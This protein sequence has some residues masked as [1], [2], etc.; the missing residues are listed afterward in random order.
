MNEQTPM[1]L[2][3]KNSQQPAPVLQG[4][5]AEGR[6]DGVL[7]ELCVRQSYR[8][9]SEEVL[10]VVYTFPLPSQGVL[11]GFASELNGKRMEGA[12]TARR[13][14]EAR[15]EAALAEGDAPVMLEALQ[16]G[17]HTANIGNLKPGEQIVLEVRFAQLLRFEQGRLR[18]A[19]PTT[20]APRFG[21]ASAAGLQPQQVPQVSMQA[22]HVLQLAITVA[23]SLA[24]A[25][26][27]CPT[28]AIRQSH[29]A[30]SVRI[31]LANQAWLDRDVVLI[32][33]PA[34]LRAGLALQAKDA[35]N[36][37]APLLH[38]AALAPW[39]TPARERINLRLLVDCSGSMGG[40]SIQSAR[41]ALASAVA[42]LR[43]QDSVSLSRFGSSVEHMARPA[44][45]QPAV[46]QQLQQRISTIQA[47]MGGTEMQAALSSTFAL[48]PPAAVKAPGIKAGTSTQVAD[49][50][51]ITDGEIWQTE[52]VIAAARASGQRIFA[53]G[54]GSSPAEH[55]LRALADATGGACEFA[56]PGE[57]LAAA[58]RRMM[59]RIRQQVWRDVR[60]EWGTEAA[61]QSAL[62]GG[63]FDGD[64]VFAWAGMAASNNAQ[65]V[66]LTAATPNGER[67]ELAR[68]AI[69]PS[70]AGISLSRMAAA[71]RMLG[72]DAST[73]LQLA[74]RYQLMSPQTNCVMVHQRAEA[75]KAAQ[76]AVLHQVTSMMAAGWGATGTVAPGTPAAAAVAPMAAAA[77]PMDALDMFSPSPVVSTSFDALAGPAAAAEAG[78]AAPQPMQRK[79]VE[80]TLPRYAAFALEKDDASQRSRKAPTGG[81]PKPAQAPQ[82]PAGIEL[83]QLAQTVV[84]LL[85]RSGSLPGLAVAMAFEAPLDEAMREV[86]QQLRALG[87]DQDAAWAVLAYWSYQRQTAT[88]P[89]PTPFAL[90]RLLPALDAQQVASATAWLDS[91]LGGSTAPAAS[92]DPSSSRLAR[93]RKALGRIGG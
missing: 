18:L 21:N 16:D 32:V 81:M 40:D 54:V 23:G 25:S 84:R 12:I 78:G 47:D 3:C 30:D 10:E 61:W 42:T 87:L 2:C 85:E 27:E 65:N 71:N 31:E 52:E 43:P 79:Q 93:L 86:L 26:I 48:Q 60:I 9:T 59:A 92:P 66:R 1:G 24:R 77:A 51:L 70:E 39:E 22:E 50:L 19:I 15:Y 35:T 58:A 33:Q 76:P 38:M 37:E 89:T 63:I 56:T 69:A 36:E 57:A 45:A 80:F 64:T 6:L 13:E 5:Q 34:E 28:H 72:A 83:M 8:N 41:E 67:I 7:F 11:L 90:V 68:A 55:V 49:V 82:E 75:D 62:P 73:A 46:I 44:H 14:A 17:L 53:I 4:V 29:A 91:H 88:P 20:I 74:L